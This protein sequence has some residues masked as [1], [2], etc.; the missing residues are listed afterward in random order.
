MR[1]W[2]EL[3]RAAGSLADRHPAELFDRFLRWVR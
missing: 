3:E 1:M 2:D